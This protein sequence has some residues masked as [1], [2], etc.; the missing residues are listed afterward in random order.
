[1]QAY[2]QTLYDYF[3]KLHEEARKA[4]EGLD[5]QSLDWS[6]GVGINS[7]AVL[8]V[9]LAAAEQFWVGDVVMGEPSGRD[10]AAEFEVRG[11]PVEELLV[12]LAA[13]EAYLQT[14][15]GKLQLQDL[16][17]ERISPRDGKTLTVGYCLAHALSHTSIHVGHLQLMRSMI[18]G[19]N[20]VGS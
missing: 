19:S 1:M 8:V 6:P 3:V 16:E 18:V 11:L 2:F 15:L 4:L 14:A 20:S 5:Q 7:M 10:R 12:R 9:H 17:A 13:S